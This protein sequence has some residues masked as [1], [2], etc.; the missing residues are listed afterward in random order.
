MLR[1]VLPRT[2]PKIPVTTPTGAAATRGVTLGLCPVRR[3][4]RG[5]GGGEQVGCGGATISHWDTTGAESVLQLSPLQI[6]ASLRAVTNAPAWLWNSP[7]GI[8][9]SRC[10]RCHNVSPA[11]GEPAAPLQC[12]HTPGT[13]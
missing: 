2:G 3:D 8:S 1:K 6:P 11:R 5:A 7:G 12:A 4:V 10:Q 13:G 9:R